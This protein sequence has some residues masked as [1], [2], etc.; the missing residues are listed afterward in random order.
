MFKM[1]CLYCSIF[2]RRNKPARILQWV[3]HRRTWIKP[4]KISRPPL[5]VLIKFTGFFILKDWIREIPFRDPRPQG[6]K[7]G[8][9]GK[10]EHREWG[11]K[12]GG[13]ILFLQEK[14]TLSELRDEKPAPHKDAWTKFLSNEDPG[15]RT[16]F[17]C[18]FEDRVLQVEFLF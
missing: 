18:E 17:E 4:V 16:V 15:Q 12:H 11:E 10:H 6:T 9:A 14:Q 7:H 13:L 2:S 3:G 8:R 1:F 5:P